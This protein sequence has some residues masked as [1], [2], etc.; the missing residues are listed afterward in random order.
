V[1]FV[2]SG[3]TFCAGFV[4]ESKGR[5]YAEMI[6]HFIEEDPYDSS[7]VRFVQKCGIESKDAKTM[8][9]KIE[10]CIVAKILSF[11]KG[12]SIFSMVWL[13]FMVM[14]YF[15]VLFESTQRPESSE[16]SRLRRL[17]PDVQT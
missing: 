6:S 11:K 15:T 13:V 9:A 16:P 12:V 5:K 10:G 7:S 4:S 17:E 1:I 2:L 3:F 8:T 14:L